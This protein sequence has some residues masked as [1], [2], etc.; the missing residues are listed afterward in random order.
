MKRIM[1]RMK[2]GQFMDIV[3]EE[4]VQMATHH[5]NGEVIILMMIVLVF[6]LVEVVY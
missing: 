4:I 2:G 3:L 1:R 5:Q 6:S